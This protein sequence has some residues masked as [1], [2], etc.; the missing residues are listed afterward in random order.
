MD[1]GFWRTEL[2]L[3]LTYFVKGIGKWGLVFPAI[4]WGA[5]AATIAFENTMVG[6]ILNGAL[7]LA[8]I[9]VPFLVAYF[10]NPQQRKWALIP[11]WVMGVLAFAVPLERYLEENLS[12]PSCGTES[13]FLS[14]WHI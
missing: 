9:A 13:G 4:I 5:I 12:A 6:E 2:I 3:F 11:A 14:C 7:I 8:A 1:G 10:E